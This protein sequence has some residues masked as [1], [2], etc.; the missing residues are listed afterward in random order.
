[1]PQIYD[2][3]EALV[4]GT[5]NSTQGTRPDSLGGTQ[6]S[7]SKR[8]ILELP[9][10]W[11]P[12]LFRFEELES[13]GNRI[14][15]LEIKFPREGSTWTGTET[16]R[17]LNDAGAHKNNTFQKGNGSQKGQKVYTQK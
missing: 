5:V 1:M 14:A 10:I 15:S 13:E 6:S 3:E 2:S 11:V 16:T 12:F 4:D 7:S 17:V 9:G 8:N